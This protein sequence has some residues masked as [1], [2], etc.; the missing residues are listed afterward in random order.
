MV[1]G[2]CVI[3][4]GQSNTLMGNDKGKTVLKQ[5]WSCINNVSSQVILWVR[6]KYLFDLILNKATNI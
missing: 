3:S 6:M 5:L 1:K 2:R 4:Q